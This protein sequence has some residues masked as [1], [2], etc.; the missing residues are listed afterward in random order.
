MTSFPCNV[1]VV[2]ASFCKTL[3]K[4]K[5]K[6][7]TAWVTMQRSLFVVED[8]I[9]RTVTHFLQYKEPHDVVVPNNCH[10]RHRFKFF[11]CGVI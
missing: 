3:S 6:N 9:K 4:K 10:L 11:V 8:F 7:D 5:L 2:I 1:F